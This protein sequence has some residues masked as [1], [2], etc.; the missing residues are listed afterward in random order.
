MVSIFEL[1]KT[2][3]SLYKTSRVIGITNGHF[4]HAG[5]L[6]KGIGVSI[7]GFYNITGHIVQ[8]A[9]SVVIGTISN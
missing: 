3:Y 8:Q 4:I 7:Y 6:L 1:F 9:K 5:P 2:N